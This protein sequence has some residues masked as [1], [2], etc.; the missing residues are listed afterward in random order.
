MKFAIRKASP[1]LLNRL[2]GNVRKLRKVRGYTQAQLGKLCGVK[3]TYISNIERAKINPTL[4]SL[5]N[6]AA[7]L[8]CTAAALVERREGCES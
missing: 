1:E 5:E 2:G 3:K 8:N 7:G 4:A 6:L